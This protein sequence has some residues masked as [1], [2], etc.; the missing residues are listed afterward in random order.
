M[1]WYRIAS[2]LRTSEYGLKEWKRWIDE[3]KWG[4]DNI[5]LFIVPIL[6]DTLC[7][8][9]C[10][11][12]RTYRVIEKLV[13]DWKFSG[14]SRTGLA[15]FSWEYFSYGLIR[16]NSKGRDR[17]ALTYLCVGILWFSWNKNRFIFHL[18]IYDLWESALWIMPKQNR[19]AKRTTGEIKTF[20]LKTVIC[21]TVEILLCQVTRNSVVIWK[22]KMNNKYR[23]I[24]SKQWVTS[25]IWWKSYTSEPYA[26]KLKMP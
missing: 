23:S 26:A 1:V 19:T 3:M 20:T 16:M 22:G 10:I 13:F 2:N 4:K 24:Q 25:G 6:I 11:I 21:R 18:G 15:S 12:K 9:S 14:Y 17:R 8:A 5:A 7:K